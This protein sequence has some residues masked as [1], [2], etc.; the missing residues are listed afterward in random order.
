MRTLSAILIIAAALVVATV[1]SAHATVLYSPALYNDGTGTGH[2]CTAFNK[3]TGSNIT[4]TVQLI[5]PF[6]GPVLTCGPSIIGPQTYSSCYTG[7][8][9]GVPVFC[10]ITTSSGSSTRGVLKS[11]DANFDSTSAVEAK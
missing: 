9:A 6:V 4:V 3:S 1:G 11:L 5:E 10:K 2:W 7:A 8:T